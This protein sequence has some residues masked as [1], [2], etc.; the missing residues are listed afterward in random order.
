MSTATFAQAQLANSVAAKTSVVPNLVKFSGIAKDSSGTPLAGLV[1]ITFALY[2]EQSG[3]AALWMETQNVKVDAAGHYNVS[4]GAEKSLPAD[5]FASGEPRWLGVQ[6]ADQSE[7]PRV[8]LA[9]VPY[10]LKAADAETIGGLPASAF[11]RAPTQNGGVE[12]GPQKLPPTVHGNGTIGYVPLWTAKNIIDKSS[13]FQSGVNLGIG[14]TTPGA[15][16]EVNGSS[17]FRSTLT[18]FPNGAAPALTLSGTA[19][20]VANN[21]IITFVSGQTFPGGGGGTITGVTAG[22][23][24]TGGGTSGNVTLN[25]DTTKVPLLAS[26]STFTQPQ[27]VSSSS[28][29]SLTVTSSAATARVI[30]GHATATASGPAYGILGGAEGVDGVGVWG[31]SSGSAGYGVQGKGATN[32]VLGWPF[33]NSSIWNL[34]TSVGVHGDNGAANG[35]GVLGTEDGGYGV[36]GISDG[37]VINTAGTYGAAGPPSGFGGIAGVWGDAANHVGTF[38][39]S[40]NYSGVLGESA[41]STGVT[42]VN[43]SQGYGMIAT[44]AATAH[45]YGVGLQAESFGQNVFPNGPGSDGVRGITHTTNGSGVAGI[46]D[47]PGGIGVY[48]SSAGGGPAGY[49]NGNVT[50]TGKITSY[51]NTPTVANGVPSIVF[52][53]SFSSNGT[54]NNIYQNLYTPPS[55]GVYRITAFQECTAT[56]G[57]G[58]FFSLNFIWTLPTNGSGGSPVFGPDCAAL[59]GSSGSVVAHV[60]GGTPIQYNYAGMNAPFTTLIMIER[61]L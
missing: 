8:L 40:V 18:L 39:S 27:T 43:N 3:G 25:L 42:G 4:L 45:D 31:Y 15:L 46:N 2:A 32:G 60:K 51:N 34:Y 22:T 30:F 54:G 33:I 58:T 61:I 26:P 1:G 52:Q 21:G 53:F 9:S 17:N 49:F 16:L 29:T 56:S 59:T 10:A 38:G 28:T 50:V 48:G 24:L 36:K 57:G 19:L 44:A 35:I 5:L 14:T 55:D 11:L 7:Q 41:L 47:A 37:T 12:S 23:A 13:L 6:V 20:S